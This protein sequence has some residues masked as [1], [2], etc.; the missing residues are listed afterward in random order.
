[1]D[2][3]NS[4]GNISHCPV[5]SLIDTKLRCF[6]SELHETLVLMMNRHLLHMCHI[7]SGDGRP[8]IMPFQLHFLGPVVRSPFGVNDG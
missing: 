4:Y 5:I 7:F 8:Y 3:F 1:M 2:D 6:V